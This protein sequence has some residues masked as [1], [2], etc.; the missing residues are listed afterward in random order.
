ML[1]VPPE[2]NRNAKNVRKR[3]A[4]AETGLMLINYMSERIGI[5]SLANQ[6]VLDLGCGTRFSE[7]FINLDAPIGSYTGIDVEKKVIDFLKENVSD[8]RF[9]YHHFDM[10]NTL[11]NP[12]GSLSE[13]SSPTTLGTST[14]DIACMFSVITHQNPDEATVTFKFLHDHIRANGYLFFSAFIRDDNLGYTELN[15]RRP[16]V[17]SSYSRRYMTEILTKTGWA[18]ASVVEAKPDD[19]PIQTSFLCRPA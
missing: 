17:Q 2:L 12:L 14:F 8:P 16:G 15:P 1:I 18:V 10:A 6:D 13:L 11:Y 19:I 4:A 7:S 9:S 3:G 5:D